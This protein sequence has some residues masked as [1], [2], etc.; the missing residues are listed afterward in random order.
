MIDPSVREDGET[1]PAFESELGAPNPAPKSESSDSTPQREQP[2]AQ[3]GAAELGGGER[4]APEPE[5]NRTE[6]N[7]AE[8]SR[9][10][11]EHVEPEWDAAAGQSELP[12]EEL[13]SSGDAGRSVERVQSGLP[14]GGRAREV[15][16]ERLEATRRAQGEAA[17]GDL[18]EI[19]DFDEEVV[20][21]P[22]PQPVAEPPGV[23]PFAPLPFSATSPPPRRSRLS[24]NWIALI[25]TAVGVATVSSL[26][27]LGM[28]VDLKVPVTLPTSTSAPPPQAPSA[29]EPAPPPAPKR[30]RAKEKGPPR[31]GDMRSDASVR[32]VEGKI[33]TDAFL[34]AL[35]KAGV[36]MR[37]NYRIVAS[38]KGVRD[39]DKCKKS[40]RF[41]VAID[42]ASSRVKGFEYV[43]TPEE[44]YQSL[45]G[46]GG[47]LKGSKLD[48]KVAHNPIRGSFVH[49]GKS[50][51]ASAQRGGFEA[52]LARAVA[53]AL[54][55]HMTMDEI[56]RGA[57]LRV[58]AQE[59]TVL[60]EFARYAGVEALEIQDG[61]DE[62][63]FRL[64][65][66][67]NPKERG[68]YDA[69]GHAPYEGGFRKPIKDAPMTSPFNLKR[70]HP[71]LKKVM[72]H[73]GIDFG[74]P[75]GTPVGASSSGVVSHASY[76]GPTG[77]LVKIEHGGG[78]ETGYAHLSRFAEGL[79]VGDKVKR[80]QIIGYVGSTGRS[81]GPHLHF[82][83]RKNGEFIDPMTLNMDA[84]RTLS[85]ESRAAFA[86]LKA[87]YD[88]QLDALPLPAS[89][90]AEAVASKGAEPKPEKPTEPAVAAG[91]T[92]SAA[93]ATA[94]E[95]DSGDEEDAAPSPQAPAKKPG[96]SVYL[97]DKEL[98][99]LQ[100]ASD[101]GEVAE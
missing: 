25:G 79:K 88:A 37:E 12:V 7:R 53:K 100:G 47:R 98:L 73:L 82:S 97:T 27:A 78:I 51:D 41:V 10:E 8:P 76:I 45:E 42:R 91:P 70:M 57:R 32:I 95:V 46:E 80:L 86:E 62:K 40:D 15:L 5:S 28:N 49:D 39:F 30:E 60:G 29:Q 99:E 33:G 69:E 59:V 38:M 90:P 6:P 89:L 24:P 1:D 48:L 36:E 61:P 67:D 71:I 20:E 34:K 72:P 65:Y 84:L 4:R 77:N 54:D 22:A 75:M 13:V 66:F 64:Y 85:R 94:G 43:V 101:E 68:Y 23:S 74:S 3:G 2:A 50:F 87:K 14:R 56:S 55:G 92:P 44:V 93:A 58:I 16:L 18:D 21:R 26:V 11:P 31:V 83:A 35:E 63:P 96:S 52:G 17:L 9:L 81:T 19:G